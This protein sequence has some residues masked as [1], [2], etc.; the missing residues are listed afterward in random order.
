MKKKLAQVRQR[1]V[2]AWEQLALVVPSSQA[3]ELVPVSAQLREQESVLVQGLELQQE[4]LHL[5]QSIPRRSPRLHL[6]L[7]LSEFVALQKLQR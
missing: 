3:R 2:R 1:R 5:L 7:R 6:P 4:P